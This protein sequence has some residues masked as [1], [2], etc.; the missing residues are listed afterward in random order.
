MDTNDY[1][2]IPYNKE[3]Q[4]YSQYFKSGNRHIDSFLK[5]SVSLE[6][7]FGKTYIW[8]EDEQI[9][10]YYNIGVG[11]IRS[12]E[13]PNYKIGG[14]IHLNYF[15]IDE[16]CR[17]YIEET[18]P[19]GTILK[20]SDWLMLDLKKRVNDIRDN[21]VGFSFI[22]LNSTEQGKNLYLRSDF[23]NMEDEG[24]SFDYKDDEN[25]C[26]PMFYTLDMEM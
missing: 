17:H 15:A 3:L 11:Y 18:L 19:N 5:D 20:S 7:W 4:K 22:T 8:F 12:N 14:A 25:S 9:I 16:T 10:G 23:E 26:V 2:T 13:Y 21:H 24:L 1:L 6:K